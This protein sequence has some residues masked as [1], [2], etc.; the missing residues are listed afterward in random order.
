MLSWEITQVF[1]S[2]QK[3]GAISFPK[4]RKAANLFQNFILKNMR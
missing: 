4:F 1:R 2:A 3:L